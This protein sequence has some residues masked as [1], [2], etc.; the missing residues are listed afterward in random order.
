[1]NP[2]LQEEKLLLYC[3]CCFYYFHD[4]FLKLKQFGR[5]LEYILKNRVISRN[6]R[7]GCIKSMNHGHA[8][9]YREI[10]NKI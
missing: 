4:F 10:P 5:G 8:Y 6:S 7:S 9:R 3:S 2:S 1:M